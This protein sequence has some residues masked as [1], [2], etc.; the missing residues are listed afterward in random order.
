MDKIKG[1][2]GILTKFNGK[3]FNKST[4]LKNPISNKQFSAIKESAKIEN[5]LKFSSSGGE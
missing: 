2:I 4:S 1:K 3:A 5:Y